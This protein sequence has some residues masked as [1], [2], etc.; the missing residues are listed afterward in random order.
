[1]SDK[2]KECPFC[3]GE[4]HLEKLLR[5]GY[6][7]FT[8]DPDAWAYFLACN[9]CACTGPW[10]KNPF[11]AFRQWNSRTPSNTA[12]TGLAATSAKAGEPTPDLLSASLVGC[13]PA[14]SQ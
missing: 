12:C 3:G 9:S 13:A 1:M 10:A 6:E 8:D 11:G 7:N 2:P 14:A 4:P 5:D